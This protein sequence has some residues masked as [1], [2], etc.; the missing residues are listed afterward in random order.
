MFEGVRRVST[1]RKLKYLE[2]YTT[3]IHWNFHYLWIQFSPPHSADFCE[4]TW[5]SQLLDWREK[6]SF[7]R[8]HYSITF[9]SELCVEM[10]WRNLLILQAMESNSWFIEPKLVDFAF[11]Q[12]LLM[13]KQLLFIFIP[14]YSN[15]WF[16]L[17]LIY[18]TDNK[19]T[20]SY[21]LNLQRYS[22][23]I[24]TTGSLHFLIFQDYKLDLGQV[25]VCN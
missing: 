7:Y 25:W 10:W 24:I 5:S 23:T 6:R 11:P 3:G 15:Y 8:L 14:E 9:I 21:F 17:L 22:P 16:V 18:C 4:L 1:Q 19:A 2:I 20:H 12:S 13:T